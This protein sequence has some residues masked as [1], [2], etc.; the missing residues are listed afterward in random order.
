M[1]IR[2]LNYLLRIKIKIENFKLEMHLSASFRYLNAI[3][4][5]ITEIKVNCG[6]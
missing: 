1:I 6:K 2:P 4:K 5:K 3:V